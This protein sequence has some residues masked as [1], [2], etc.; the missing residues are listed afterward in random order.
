MNE[1][2]LIIHRDIIN[3][4]SAPSPQ[5]MQDL[6]KPFQEWIGGIAAQNKLVAQPKRLD[7]SGKVVKEGFVT[8]GPYAEVKESVGGLI[9]VRA[10]DYDEAVEL[11]KGCPILKWGASL[12]VRLTVPNP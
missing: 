1:Y 12:E 3:K 2:L 10:K 8:D 11:A 7:Y 4:A 9:I 5:Q 6:I